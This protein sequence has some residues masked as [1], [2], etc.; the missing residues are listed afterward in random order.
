MD[1]LL[2]H[3]CGLMYESM[4]KF[5]YILLDLI[6]DRLKGLLSPRLTIDKI[7]ESLLKVPSC[8]DEEFKAFASGI[9]IEQLTNYKAPSI[10][11]KHTMV[12]QRSSLPKNFTP[13]DN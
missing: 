3:D 11:R 2:S 5:S 6:A 4:M 10:T 8:S 7:L 13:L 9:E 1:Y 12:H